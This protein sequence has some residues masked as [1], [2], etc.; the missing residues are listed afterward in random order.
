MIPHARSRSY[1]GRIVAAPVSCES[2]GNVTNVRLLWW[3]RG[4]GHGILWQGKHI[5][6]GHL[7][8]FGLGR[9]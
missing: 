7:F 6:S 1:C 4:E 8:W 5:L 3:Q 9:G 2:S